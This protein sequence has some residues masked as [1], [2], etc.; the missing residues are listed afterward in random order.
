M[1][2]ELQEK[3]TEELL[4]QLLAYQKK[5]VRQTRLAT[6]I[7]FLLVVAVIA[8]LALL[9]PRVLKLAGDVETSLGEVNRV[10]AS[11]QELIGNANAMVEENTDAVT[12]TIRKLNELDFDTLNTAIRNLDDAVSPLAELARKLS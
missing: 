11:A 8:A 2:T 7:N 6:F 4:R 3:N 5:E 12:E 1:N 9:T 10:T